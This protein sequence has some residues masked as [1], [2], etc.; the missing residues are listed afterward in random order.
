MDTMQLRREIKSNQ[1]RSCRSWQLRIQSNLSLTCTVIGRVPIAKVMAITA[2]TPEMES[3]A[4]FLA[5]PARAAA[6]F[7]K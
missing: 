7:K 3:L 5:F 6:I 2:T 4:T 1:P